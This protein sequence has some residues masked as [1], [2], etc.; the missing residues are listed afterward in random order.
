MPSLVGRLLRVVV[1]LA[2]ARRI[3]GIILAVVGW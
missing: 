1:G 2:I 3:G